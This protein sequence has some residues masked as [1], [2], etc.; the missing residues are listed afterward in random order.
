MPFPER[1]GGA[2][3]KL[4]TFMKHLD[5]KRIEV[6]LAFL[7]SGDLEQDVRALGLPTYVL[8]TA[9]LRRGGKLVPTVRRLRRIFKAEQPELILNWGTK[10]QVL[11]WPAASLAGFGDRVVW[12]QLAVPTKRF[13]AT[14]LA[15]LL[16]ARAVMASSHVSARA[17]EAS[18]PRRSTFVVHP[19]IDPPRSVTAGERD[20]LR[21]SLGIPGDRL[22]VGTVGRLQGLKR[23]DLLVRALATLR[24]RGHEIHGLLVGGNA[25]NLDPG[26]E[27]SLHG[28]VDELRMGDRMAFAG[29]VSDPVPYL[30]L[31]D[32]FVLPSP[33]E[34]FGIAVTEAMANGVAS[35]AVGIS[36]PAEIIENGRSG[37]LVERADAGLLVEAIEPLLTDSSQRDCLAR[38]GQRRQRELFSATRMTEEMTER[39]LEITAQTRSH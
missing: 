12:T 14:R 32:V 7:G 21:S 18:W 36:G 37:L 23:Q 26:Y 17:Q 33:L 20:A 19:G 28:L 35:I 8:P 25:Y 6:V 2:E 30:Q 16:P 39:L 15:T 29:Q 5:R 24:E 4:Y 34:G 3:N 22:V 31:M 27:R 10:A 11:G 1:V 9:R 13:D 38:E